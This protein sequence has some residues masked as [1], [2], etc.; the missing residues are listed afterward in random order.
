MRIVGGDFGGRRFH[1]PAKIPA[2]P[3]TEV[4]KEG[5]FNILNNM[6][7]FEGLKTCDI[8]GGTGSISY[9]L[10]SRDRKSTRLHSSHVKISYAVFCLKKKIKQNSVKAKP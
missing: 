1:P 8:F 5:L 7:D 9:E 10:A 3:T 2:R 6:M 4:A